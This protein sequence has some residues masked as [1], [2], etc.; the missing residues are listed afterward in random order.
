LS[1]RPAGSPLDSVAAADQ[2]PSMTANP[3][4][5]SRSRDQRIRVRA[6]QLWE[7][8]GRPEGRHD[9]FWERARELIAIEDNPHSGQ[10]PNPAT[11]PGADPDRSEPIE[12]AFIEENLGEFP[13]RLVDQGERA[14]TPSKARRKK[15]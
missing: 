8:D 13:G 9:E 5:D 2:E 11:L 7:E 1:R 4:D 12:E 10:L 14:Q 15:A 6:Y 3:L